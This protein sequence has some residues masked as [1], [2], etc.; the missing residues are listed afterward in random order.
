MAKKFVFSAHRAKKTLHILPQTYNLQTFR[1]ITQ[2]S[3]LPMFSMLFQ[4]RLPWPIPATGRQVSSLSPSLSSLSLRFQVSSLSPSLF[5][6]PPCLPQETV[7]HV[8]AKH[9]FTRM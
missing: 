1:L 4:L 6:F 3:A 5:P 7:I 2:P 9:I 8:G